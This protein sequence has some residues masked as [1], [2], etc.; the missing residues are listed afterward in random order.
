MSPP[1]SAAVIRIN[2]TT[3]N[4]TL[5]SHPV[6]QHK[7]DFPMTMDSPALPPCDGNCYHVTCRTTGGCSVMT[8]E[9]RCVRDALHEVYVLWWHGN[10]GNHSCRSLREG[11]NVSTGGRLTGL[12]M[13]PNF[14]G[15]C[16]CGRVRV[17]RSAQ[18]QRTLRSTK[19][20]FFDLW[21]GMRSGRPLGCWRRG[22]WS[23]SGTA[24]SIFCSLHGSRWVDRTMAR[25]AVGIMALKAGPLSGRPVFVGGLWRRG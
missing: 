10:P 18:A 17:Y 4:R 19:T 24:G 8:V 23:H 14:W 2:S 5:I 6:S 20:V 12:I 15:K 7:W 11:R 16:R 1:T 21:I 25:A 22:N 9:F 13:K 3:L